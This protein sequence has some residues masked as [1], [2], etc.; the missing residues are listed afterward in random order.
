MSFYSQNNE[1]EIITE[2]F[3]DR[4]GNFLDIGAYDGIAMSNTRKLLENGWAGVLVEPMWTSFEKLCENCRPFQE[5][6]KLVMAAVGPRRSVR[7]IW[8]DMTDMR[9]WS[10]TVNDELKESGSVRQPD[11]LLTYV[12]TILIQELLD[13]FGPFEFVSID[14]EWEDLSILMGTSTEDWK[15][16]ELLCV[17]YRNNQEKPAVQ[18]R[19]TALGFSQLYESKENIIA[20]NLCCN[21]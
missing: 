21:P 17:E 12:P 5:R 10:T 2:F 15:H 14:A 4:K 9:E 16:T 6:V 20:K 11:E 18:E 13:G 19:L 8:V 3:G 1:E 7:R